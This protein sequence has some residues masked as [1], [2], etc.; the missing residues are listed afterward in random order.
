MRYRYS[1]FRLPYGKIN[2]LRTYVTQILSLLALKMC[3][4]TQRTHKSIISCWKFISLLDLIKYSM[5]MRSYQSPIKS[6]NMVRLLQCDYCFVFTSHLPL[7][8]FKWQSGRMLPA[9]HLPFDACAYWMLLAKK[10]M[11]MMD[12]STERGQK[13][14]NTHTTTAC[15]RY[16]TSFLPRD[17]QTFRAYSYNLSRTRPK[18][19][20]NES[21]STVTETISIHQHPKIT[22]EWVDVEI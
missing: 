14:R 19:T 21:S 9:P 7:I 1:I 17:I 22:N 8:L 20:K 11:M 2:V 18:A 13:K 10:R 16:K 12:E 5:Q 3:L 4:V 15:E 6:N